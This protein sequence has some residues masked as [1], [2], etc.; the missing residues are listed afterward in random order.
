MD[1]VPNYSLYNWEQLQDAHAHINRERYPVNFA[2]LE[3]EM[4]RRR[5]SSLEAEGG[6]SGFDV[7]SSISEDAFIPAASSRG[8]CGS[9]FYGW[10]AG[11]VIGAVIGQSWFLILAARLRAS[12]ANP[13]GHDDWGFGWLG[14]LF[15]SVSICSLI[16]IVTGISRAKRG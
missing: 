14:C 8:G 4:E 7:R 9:A 10:L 11:T 5:K 3:K 15:V 16:G 13:Y 2:A 12:G 6:W 1:D